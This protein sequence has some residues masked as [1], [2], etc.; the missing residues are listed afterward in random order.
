LLNSHK[1]SLSFLSRVYW[2]TRT[3][4]RQAKGIKFNEFYWVKEWKE[5]KII[6]I[7]HK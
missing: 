7:W 3:T 5:R 2:R 4:K 6:R 1:Q